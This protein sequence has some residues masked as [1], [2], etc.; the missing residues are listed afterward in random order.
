MCSSPDE[1]VVEQARLFLGQDEDPTGTVGKA[2]KHNTM[3][4]PTMSGCHG[5]LRK[6]GLSRSTEG[7]REGHTTLRLCWPCFMRTRRT[8]ST[9][10]LAISMT[11]SAMFRL[12]GCCGIESHGGSLNRST[13]PVSVNTSDGRDNHPESV[14]C[15]TMSAEVIRVEIPSGGWRDRPWSGVT[16]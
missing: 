8:R 12:E 10:R 5:D 1:A 6:G 15:L 3:V 2:F 4:P 13:L 9:P 11:T 7:E 14:L 16:T